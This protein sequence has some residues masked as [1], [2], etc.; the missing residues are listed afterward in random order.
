MSTRHALSGSRPS[1]LGR[2]VGVAGGG[3]F[4]YRSLAVSVDKIRQPD[5]TGAHAGRSL[6]ASCPPLTPDGRVRGAPVH[7][8]D[9]PGR[10]PCRRTRPSGP[11]SAPVQ[12]AGGAD[13]PPLRRTVIPDSRIVGTTP[14]RTRSRTLR[15]RPCPLHSD[16]AGDRKAARARTIAAIVLCPGPGRLRVAASAGIGDGRPGRPPAAP[17]TRSGSAPRWGAGQTR[18][19]LR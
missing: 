16:A 7:R 6:R 14:I 2:E 3:R 18:L 4:V 9:A 8:G 19:V 5:C 13:G 10:H 11:L 15:G 12:E 17:P 1:P